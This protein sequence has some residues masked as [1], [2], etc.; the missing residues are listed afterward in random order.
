M[1]RL[2]GHGAYIFEAT[3]TNTKKTVSIMGRGLRALTGRSPQSM[4]DPRPFNPLISR[5]SSNGG[6]FSTPS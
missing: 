6:Y 3:A 1:S 2:A 5:K 4:R